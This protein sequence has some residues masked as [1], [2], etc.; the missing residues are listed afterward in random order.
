MRKVK[1]FGL[2]FLMIFGVFGCNSNSIERA[3]QSYE[4]YSKLSKE[5]QE[6]IE[7]RKA[8]IKRI[9]EIDEKVYESGLEYTQDKYE[10]IQRSLQKEFTMKRDGKYVTTNDQIA[11][12]LKDR[13]VDYADIID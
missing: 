11:E 13:E 3:C 9:K 8:L 5:D 12:L 1:I 10:S 6:S 4:G 7:C 2:L